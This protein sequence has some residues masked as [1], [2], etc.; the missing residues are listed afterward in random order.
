MTEPA[1][2]TTWRPAVPV[3][4]DLA[5]GPLQRGRGD[6][7]HLR[8]PAGGW[9]RT[10][11]TPAGIA[12]LHL[13]AAGRDVHAAAW[14]PGADWAIDNVP[15]LLGAGDDVAGFEP[16]HPVIASTWRRLRHLRL[17]ATGTVFE[18]LAPSVLEQRVTGVEAHRSWR[19]LLRRYGDTAPGPA[20]S[21]MRVVPAPEVWARIPSWEWHRANVDPGRART[22]RSA[23]M[24][25]GRLEEA[26][27]LP[28]DQRLKR[29]RYVPGVGV[30]TAAEV[31]QRSWGDPDAVS[32]G[33]FH[34]P[35]LVGW[36]LV[37]RP[38][39]DDEMLE[40]LSCYPG[41]RHRAV[42]LVEASGVR[43]PGF[44]PRMTVGD[45]RAI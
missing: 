2:Q 35:A 19:D 18:L 27:Q 3:S 30:W 40:L 11:R 29:L 17:G 44:G 1:A 12:T 10:S 31:A 37:G 33:D 39:D 14:G 24:V 7:A 28:R 36:A 34:I 42:R 41:H 23:A 13:S 6:P 8:D 32:V 43:K 4:L 15:A 26:T 20:P 16:Q 5:I 38:V 22:I 21:G 9:W 45:I 25:A